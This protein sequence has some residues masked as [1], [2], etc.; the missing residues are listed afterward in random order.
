VS[1]GP[2]SGPVTDPARERHLRSV[3]TLARLLDEAVRIPGIGTKVGLDALIGLVPGAGDAL[4]AALSGWV[5][6]LAARLG[7]PPAILA[8]MAGNAALDALAGSVPLLGD[9]FDIGWRANSRNVALLERWLERP[10]E[11]RATSMVVVVLLLVLLA[12][13]VVGAFWLAVRVLGLIVGAIS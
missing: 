2:L 5:I 1:E 3:R 13:L 8:R 12:A 11:T 6:I 4:G 10:R 9:L 7:A